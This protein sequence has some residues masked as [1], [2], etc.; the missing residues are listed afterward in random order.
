MPNVA[1]QQKGPSLLPFRYGTVRRR[2][3]MGSFTVAPGQAIPTQV[4]PQVG[5]LSRILVSISG[6]YTVGVAPTTLTQLDGYDAIVQRVSVSANNGS[7]SIVNLSGIGVL[8]ANQAISRSLP[9]KKGSLAV[10][11]GAQTYSY[12]FILPV[13]ANDRRQFEMGLINL[14]APEIRVSVD[15]SLNQL[16]SIFTV[17]A[18]I[19]LFT[20]TVTL[21]YEYFEIP[22]PTRF[23]LP[24]LTIVRTLED[25]PVPV[26]AVG[27]SIYQI[28]RQ[29]TMFNY[30]AVPVNAT[31]GALTYP[32][33]DSFASNFQWRYNLSDTTVNVPLGGGNSAW[34]LFEAMSFQQFEDG[35]GGFLN[36]NF[37]SFDL[38]NAG[39]RPWDGGDFR[40]AIDTEQNTTTQSIITVGPAFTQESSNIYHIRRIVQRI[41]QAP[42][43]MAA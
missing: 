9:L 24:P 15:L 23:A 33:I 41:T 32:G 35:D 34:E 29:G 7:A 43:P 26:A 22:D 13:N 4:V 5:M 20:A 30:F 25:A 19:T 8:A 1:T 17:P 18:D 31:A 2:V 11:A 36:S 21:T 39:D 14:Q 16:A 28:P 27:D 38:W 10:T 3:P 40:D 42:A 12:G 6:G 37:L